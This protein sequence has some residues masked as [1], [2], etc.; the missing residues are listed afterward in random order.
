MFVWAVVDEYGSFILELEYG[1]KDVRRLNITW[2]PIANKYR[3]GKMKRTLK[4]EF[5]STWN[6][7]W[8]IYEVCSRF[9]L[10]FAIVIYVRYK[11]FQFPKCQVAQSLWEVKKIYYEMEIT[12]RCVLSFCWCNKSSKW[13]FPNDQCMECYRFSR[14]WVRVELI[15][16]RSVFSVLNRICTFAVEA[17]SWDD[18]NFIYAGSQFVGLIEYRFLG[19][20]CH[21]NS[22]T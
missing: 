8:E 1:R 3:E 20:V 18:A 6:C 9:L 10:Y 19:K 11:L 15:I 13:V 4:R 16:A 22:F 5:K 17:L 7:Q 2:A 21:G 12:P 14:C